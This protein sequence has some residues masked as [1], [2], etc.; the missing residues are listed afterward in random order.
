MVTIDISGLCYTL[1]CINILPKVKQKVT[2]HRGP[3]LGNVRMDYRYLGRTGVRVSSPCL[4]CMMLGGRAGLEETCRNVDRVLDASINFFDTSNSCGYGCSKKFNGNALKRRGQRLFA[5]PTTKVQNNMHPACSDAGSEQQARLNPNQQG[6]SRRGTIEQCE[7]SLQRLQTDYIDLYQIHNSQPECAID[8]TLRAL[9]DLVRAGKVR[10]IGTSSFATWLVIESLWVSG[11]LELNRVMT[12]QPPYNLLDRRIE[13]DL[14]P[15]AQTY[16]LV[17]LS[18]SPLASEK[19][20][21]PS[22]QPRT[23]CAGQPGITSPIKGPRTLAQLDDNL[24]SQD[25]VISD[26]NRKRID[27]FSPP[28]THEAPFYE[29]RFGPHHHRV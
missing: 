7:A 6:N 27:A 16:D 19:G 23:W 15:M 8:E 2:S 18:W 4:G 28:G 3:D 29:A 24:A 10:Y 22:Q 26:E 9:D 20:C 21:T 1:N 5:M 12:A 14:I 11:N 13:R 17:L 25:V